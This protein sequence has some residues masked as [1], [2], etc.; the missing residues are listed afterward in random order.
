[1]SVF[2]VL[3]SSDIANERRNMGKKLFFCVGGMFTD[4]EIF[5]P[6]FASDFDIP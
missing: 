6:S 5:F 2:Y 3:Y 1:M 4:I